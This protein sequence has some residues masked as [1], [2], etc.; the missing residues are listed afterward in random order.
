MEARLTKV[1]QRK[2]KQDG[3]EDGGKVEGIADLDFDKK[4][5]QWQSTQVSMKERNTLKSL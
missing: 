3:E 5:G 2:L 1:R 4:Q